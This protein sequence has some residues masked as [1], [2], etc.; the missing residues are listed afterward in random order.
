MSFAPE[1][2]SDEIKKHI[3]DFEITY[4]VDPIRQSIA[5]SWPNSIDPTC[6]MVEWGFKVNYD[7]VKMTDDMLQKLREKGINPELAIA[8]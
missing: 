7:L 6:A 1:E 8:K 3:P 5:D 4:N 2:I